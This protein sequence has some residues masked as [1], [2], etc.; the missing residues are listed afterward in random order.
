M[1]R[2]QIFA[3]SIFLTLSSYAASP[4]ILNLGNG[5]EPKDLDPHVTTGIPEFHIQMNIF[6]GL[7]GK[8]PKTLAP[9][10]AVAESWQTSK[11]GKVWTFKLRKSARWSNGE[12]VTADDFVYSFAR[13]L[14]PATASEY[15]YQGYYIK[16][17]KDYNTGKTKDTSQLGVKAVNPQ[18]LQ[19]TLEN[20]TPFFLD[21][22]YHHSLMP[23]PKSAIEKHGVRWT[24]PENLVSN[25]PFNVDRW[26]TNKVLSAKKS[27]TYWDKASVKLERVNFLPI[28]KIE[29]E[30][31]LFR[32]KEIHKTNEI[33]VEKLPT[34][35]ADKT[36]VY[37]N[38]PYLG[39]Y[40]YWLNTTKKPLN[41]VRVRKAL[42]YAIDRTK[43]V[44][45]VTR[46]GQLPAQAF[47][48]P[49]TGG[50]TP[51]QV[52]PTDLSRLAEA[53]KLLAEAGY[54]DGKGF[55]SVEI[56]YNTSENHKK[57]A[58]AIQQMW[59]QNLGVSATLFNQEW[60]V[61]LD[62]QQT[63][64]YTISRAGWIA[65]Y[66]DP[67][68]FLDM[69][70]SYAQTNYSGWAKPE[71]DALIEAASKEPNAKKRLEH[72][73][74]AESILLEEL[75]CMPIYVYTRAYLLSTDV[76]G[77]YDNIQDIHPLKFVSLGK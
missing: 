68:T 49:G 73:A 7:V 41:D 59:K 69:F 43:I 40:H 38:F 70:T 50:Y 1:F 9:I 3:L 13:L 24:R 60:K 37:H 65:D 10:P 74:K 36:G 75:P 6:E 53:K 28:E 12:P 52:L 25:G 29:T 39:I 62:N 42:A 66:N 27:V 64:N 51:P 21:I 2:M 35:Q 17:G 31:K 32:S 18:T 16:G 56:L 57:I 8:D 23:V 44:K 76:K 5:G 4:Q 63:K 15:A 47:T 34:W 22:L 20:P 72:F 11:D 54:P 55:P 46:A 58:E 48:P 14:N 45:F 19:V 67:N 30:E 71:Y 26:E 61:Y 33:P 77:W